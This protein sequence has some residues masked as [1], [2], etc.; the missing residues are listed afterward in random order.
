MTIAPGSGSAL[1]AA[2]ATADAAPAT[3]ASDAGAGARPASKVRI[4]AGSGGS[5]S[6]SA[7]ATTRS[8]APALADRGDAVSGHGSIARHRPI[9]RVQL[10]SQASN[11]AAL[12]DWAT[13]SSA[14]VDRTLPS[15]LWTN[16]RSDDFD[17][18]DQGALDSAFESF[19]A[20]VS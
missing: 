8:D 7:D 13:R 9:G 12:I 17:I 4:V 3:T 14:S 1:A 20:V 18:E 10:T 6:K 5:A 2:A 19:E 16:D 15:D 11:D